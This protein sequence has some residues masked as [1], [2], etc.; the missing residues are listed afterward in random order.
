M[1]TQF[2]ETIYYSISGCFF[3]WSMQYAYSTM[4][5][6]KVQWHQSDTTS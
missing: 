4:E 1:N 2:E 5:G 3:A 6:Y